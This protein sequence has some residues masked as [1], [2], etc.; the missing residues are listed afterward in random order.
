[1]TRLLKIGKMPAS[2]N[3]ADVPRRWNR[4]VVRIGLRFSV[5]LV[6]PE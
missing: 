2:F 5:T 1:V 6:F 3:P 4:V